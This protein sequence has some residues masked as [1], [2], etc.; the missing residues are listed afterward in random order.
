MDTAVAAVLQNVMC[1]RAGYDMEDA[2]ILNKSA[3]ERGL[4]HS[5]LFKCEAIDLRE[6][7]G[8]SQV[9]RQGPGEYILVLSGELPCFALGGC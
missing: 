1:A 3:V 5:T 2:M 7:K 6:D 9:R 8:K 4:A